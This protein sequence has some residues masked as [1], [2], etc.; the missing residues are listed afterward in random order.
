MATEAQLAREW[1]AVVGAA[2]SLMGTGM[3]SRARRHAEDNMIWQRQRRLALGAPAASPGDER[4]DARR[5]VVAYRAAG[6]TF[7]GA[8]LLL[9]AV[10]LWKPG[11]LAAW[12]RFPQLGRGG[13]LT[14]GLLL[15]TAGL[16]LAWTKASSGEGARPFGERLA[17]V[18]GWGLSFLLSAY[19]L[20]LLRE[21]LR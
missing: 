16:G 2:F 5:L 21:A 17:H 4:T 1:T 10:A 9:L 20:R 7:A 6:S 13:I 12:Q 14:G 15:S 8:G 11:A 3:A 19:G 18:C